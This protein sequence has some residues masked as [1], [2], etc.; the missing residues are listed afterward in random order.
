VRMNNNIIAGIFLSGLLLGSGPCLV[1][2]GPLLISYI[3]GTSKNVGQALSAYLIFSLSR[4]VV[5]VI[6]GLMFFLCGQFVT[7]EF[8]SL[9]RRYIFVIAGI[10]I[11][12]IGILIILGRGFHN[13]ICDK[14]K[15]TLI[16]KDVKTLVLIGLVTGISPCLPLL[17]VL[18]YVGLVSKSWQSSM[19][20]GFS[21]GV[22][23]SISALIIPVISCGLIPRFFQNRPR[24]KVMINLVCGCILVILGLQLILKGWGR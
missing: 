20:Y 2:C 5:Y 17:S 21:F 9:S 4:I 7:E 19:L 18:S 23:T 10:F 11:C 15:D 1:S 24:L 16:G 13:R 12:I 6:L 8:F 3:T 22:G 14:F